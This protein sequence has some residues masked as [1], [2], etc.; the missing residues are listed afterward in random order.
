MRIIN[1]INPAVNTFRYF[2]NVK[3]SLAGLNNGSARCNLLMKIAKIADARF[4]HRAKV[5]RLFRTPELKIPRWIID[6]FVNSHLR[7]SRAL[8]PMNN[9]RVAAFVRL[10]V[11]STLDDSRAHAERKRGSG[12]GG[13]RNYNI[14]NS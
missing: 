6:A 12:G 3:H 8:T 13:G 14:V 2:V 10:R 7:S 4:K 11:C 5:S 1:G 9:A